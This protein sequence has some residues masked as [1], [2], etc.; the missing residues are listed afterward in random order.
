MEM[1]MTKSRLYVMKNYS[2]LFQSTRNI[3]MDLAAKYKMESWITDG[4]PQHAGLQATCT[5]IVE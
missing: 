1:K 3:W 4:D 5:S 2:N